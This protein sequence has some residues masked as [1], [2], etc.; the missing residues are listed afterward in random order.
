MEVTPLHH[1]P[2]PSADLTDGFCSP[3]SV[4]SSFSYLQFS[5]ESLMVLPGP[6]SSL[7]PSD[8]LCYSTNT[9]FFRS[10]HTTEPSRA[11]PHINSFTIFFTLEVFDWVNLKILEYPWNVLFHFPNL[12]FLTHWQ[13]LPISVSAA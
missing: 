13:L 4:W 8:S 3:L 2:L 9:D 10:Y 11:P 7:S 12:V 5:Y 6:C 1:T